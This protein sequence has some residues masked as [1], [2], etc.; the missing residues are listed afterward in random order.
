MIEK[1][2]KLICINDSDN[3]LILYEKYKGTKYNNN[4]SLYLIYDNNWKI[5]GLFPPNIFKLVEELRKERLNK[6]L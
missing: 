1:F 2:K 3:R 5:I 4:G 6:I